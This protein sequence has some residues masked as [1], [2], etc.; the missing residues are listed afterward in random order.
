MKKLVKYTFLTLCGITATTIVGV[1]GIQQWLYKPSAADATEETSRKYRGGMVVSAHPLASQIGK[2]VLVKGGNAYDAAIAVNFALTVVYPQAGNIGGGGFLVYRT[3]S[4]ESGALDFREKAPLKAHRDMFLGQSGNVIDGLSRNSHL[5]SGVPG[6]VDGMVKLHERLG[7]VAWSELLA[8]SVQLSRQ[9]FTLTKRGA[10]E[11]NRFQNEF[12]ERN[13]FSTR[14]VQDGGWRGGDHISFPE[15]ALTL[16]RIA[17]AGR[18]GFY[19]GE[20]AELLRAE[21]EA[22]GGL[23]TQDDLDEFQSVWRE[24]VRSSYRGFEVIAMPL[25][26]SG[27]IALSQMLRG[28][29][30]YDLA[31]MQHNSAE[32]VHLMTELQRRVYA[33][34][35]EWLGDSDFVL[36]DTA[37]L[38]SPDYI[39]QRMADIDLSKK[40]DSQSVKPGEVAA[41]ESFET[42]HFSIVDR[43]GNAVSVTTTLNGFFGSKIVVKGAG[44]LLN[45]EMD[46]FSIKPGVPNA[47]GLVGNENNSIA[48]GKRMLSSMTPTIV[49]RD[50]QLFMVLGSPGG[51]TIITTVFQVI[52]NVIDFGLSL[53]AAVD[54]KKT[55]S[56]WLPDVVMVEKGAMDTASLLRFLWRGHIPV[57]W[58]LFNWELGRVN[59]VRVHSDGSLEGA[60]DPRGDDN[61]S[62]G[63]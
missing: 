52:S 18:A 39:D 24:P 60:A 57:V 35:A 40:T 61:A 46:D 21:M 8:P 54:A 31:D 25:P 17:D 6:S 37:K 55:H 58:P 59:A 23:I 49:T 4:G 7:S 42:T 62:M 2:E 50:D 3:A 15:L 27:G 26:S 12:A 34:R 43:W 32:H 30:A 45:K 41:I 16:E 48:P 20:T 14:F 38:L 47:F 19:Q 36:V 9:G 1:L 51:S 56:Q 63:L 53:Q 33:D 28:A 22:G 10:S 29:E 11:I 44:F 13:R 5:A